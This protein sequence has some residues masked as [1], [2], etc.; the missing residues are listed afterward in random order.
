MGVHVTCQR[1]P[2][3]WA[4]EGGG[5]YDPDSDLRPHLQAGLSH[6][7]AACGGEPAVSHEALR[8][9]RCGDCESRIRTAEK[10]GLSL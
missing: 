9:L 6:G 7:D 8:G 10:W 5:V 1:S 2:G 4:G 3:C